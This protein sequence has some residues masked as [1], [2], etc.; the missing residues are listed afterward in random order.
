MYEKVYA[1]KTQIM[2]KILLES[3]RYQNIGNIDDGRFT[4]VYSPPILALCI[5]RRLGGT[6]S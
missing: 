4:D 1:D 6:A 3:V 2:I 5:D